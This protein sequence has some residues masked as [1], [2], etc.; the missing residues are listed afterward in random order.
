MCKRAD[1]E[2]CK[3][4]D[5]LGWIYESRAG[6]GSTYYL[7]IVI[8]LGRSKA[9]DAESE[10]KAASCPVRRRGRGSPLSF[11]LGNLG[12]RLSTHICTFKKSKVTVVQRIRIPITAHI[13]IR[14]E[15]RGGIEKHIIIF[16]DAYC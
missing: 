13:M 3:R 12:H 14:I 4:C 5:H 16:V 11:T 1:S 6:T 15:G 7:L 10:L 9:S 8:L 2:E